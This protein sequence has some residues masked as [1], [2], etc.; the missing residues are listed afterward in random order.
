MIWLDLSPPPV[1][2][3]LRPGGAESR[4]SG[5]EGVSPRPLPSLRCLCLPIR[6]NGRPAGYRALA[7]QVDDL[8]ARRRQGNDRFRRKII[9][10]VDDIGGVI[11]FDHRD[12]RI[13]ERRD[14]ADSP[15]EL[16]RLDEDFFSEDD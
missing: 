4:S 6:P 13:M 5:C 14:K 7:R 8:G 3:S 15:I 9:H 2:L 11:A 10:R 12:A 1:E 16:K